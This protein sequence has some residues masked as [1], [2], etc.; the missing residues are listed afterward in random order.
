MRPVRQGAEATISA[1]DGGGL[2]ATLK[3]MED[4]DIDIRKALRR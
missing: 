2:A 1:G 3:V 4:L